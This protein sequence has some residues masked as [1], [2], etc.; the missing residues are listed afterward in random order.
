MDLKHLSALQQKTHYV[1][2]SDCKN[3]FC[4]LKL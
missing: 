2:I 3:T 4:I 1:T